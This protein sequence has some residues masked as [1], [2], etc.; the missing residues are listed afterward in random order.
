MINGIKAVLAGELKG[1]PEHTFVGD[2]L[3]YDFG[4]CGVICRS[5]LIGDKEKNAI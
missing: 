4:T 1:T 3:R 2:G 5:S